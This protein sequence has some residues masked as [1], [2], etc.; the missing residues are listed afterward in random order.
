MTAFKILNE[1]IVFADKLIIQK[2]EI[3]NGNKTFTRL[4]INREDAV[5]VF[6]LNTDSNMVILTR[7]F[8]YPI[9][10]KTKENILEIMAGKIDEGE[11]PLQAAIRETKE[12]TGYNIKSENIRLLFSCFSSPGYSSERFFIYYA[13]VTN[14]DKV[15]EGGGNK[16][17]NEEIEIVP[18]DIKEF[19]EMITEGSIKDAKTYLAGMYMASHNFFNEQ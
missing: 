5:A 15:S 10:S 13:T 11:E 4:Q 7:Q 19:K 3:N 2:G 9:T 14:A 18:I 17:E 16:S 1:R 8:R 12:E 6:I